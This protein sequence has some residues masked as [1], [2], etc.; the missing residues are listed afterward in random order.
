MNLLLWRHAQAE[1]GVPDLERRLTEHG[2]RDAAQMARWLIPRL[3]KRCTVM[4]SPAVRARETAAALTAHPIIDERLAPQRDVTDYLAAA[5]W[6]QDDDTAL[7]I[8]A[9]QP[10]LGR[11]AALVLCGVEQPWS[12]RKCALWWLAARVRDARRQAVLR[13]VIDAEHLKN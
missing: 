1:D 10:V 8:V 11:L 2:K 13:L 6:P 7:I 12:M 4:S 9:H 5:Q 3:P